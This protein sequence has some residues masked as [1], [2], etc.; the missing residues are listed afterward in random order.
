[1]KI[2]SGGKQSLIRGEMCPVAYASRLRGIRS[3]PVE[4]VWPRESL[5]D[6]N[7]AAWADEY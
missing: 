5:W 2:H 6:A 1:M 4:P 3:S 7:P